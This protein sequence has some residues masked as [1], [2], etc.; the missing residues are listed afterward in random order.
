MTFRILENRGSA[1]N[2]W[3]DL[4]IAGLVGAILALLLVVL[5]GAAWGPL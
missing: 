3:M 4:I 1:L 5:A 2:D